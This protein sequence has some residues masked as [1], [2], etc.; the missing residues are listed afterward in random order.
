MSKPF[1]V[2]KTR[3]KTITDNSN[4]FSQKDFLFSKRPEIETES[5]INAFKARMLSSP[6]E[7][8]SAEPG[9]YT[10]IIRD[11]KKGDDTKIYALRTISK[12][13]VG[14]LHT[15]IKMYSDRVDPNPIV[16]AGELEIKPD[17]TIYFNI[18]SGTFMK[19]IFD[20]LN[21]KSQQI[22][23]RNKLAA[24]FISLFQNAGINP[25]FLECTSNNRC[26]EEELLGGKKLIEN[27][28]IITPV[29][30]LKFLRQ[31]FTSPINAE[32]NAKN[33]SGG[34]R[35]RKNRRRKTRKARSLRNK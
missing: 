34:R 10:W 25:I 15:N 29:K 32:I 20:R 28:D 11:S 33:V 3:E 26:S 5:V 35:T 24:K 9:Y 22:N 6:Y 7:F 8:P 17:G 12:Q 1:F 2:V 31:Y 27:N 13:E 18:L 4:G 30:N 21:G 23:L 19:P 16:A 14:T